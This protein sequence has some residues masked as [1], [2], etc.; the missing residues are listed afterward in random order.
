MSYTTFRSVIIIRKRRQFLRKLPI[1]KLVQS[2]LI[3]LA[4]FCLTSCSRSPEQTNRITDT[5]RKLWNNTMHHYVSNNLWSTTNSYDAGHHVMLP[6]HVAYWS[7]EESWIEDIRH[8]MHDSVVALVE[9]NGEPPLETLDWIHYAYLMSRYITLEPLCEELKETIAFLLAEQISQLWLEKPAWMWDREPFSCMRERIDWKLGTKETEYS[10]YR[11]ILDVDIYVMAI[12]ADL[13]NYE[14]SHK[15]IL[16][17][18]TSTL[19]EILVYANRVLIDR[20]VYVNDEAWLFQPGLWADHR[21]YAYA[22]LS[23]KEGGATQIPVAQI[24]EDSSH[25]H[26]LP[27]W[28]SSLRDAYADYE[29]EYRYYSSLLDGLAHQVLDKVLKAPTK[30]FNGIRMTN[31]MDGSN[32]L[33]RWQY[34]T[35]NGDGYG[36]YELSLTFLLGWW[37]FTNNS[38]IKS[39]YLQ[40]ATCFP[41]TDDVKTTYIGPNTTRVRDAYVTLPDSLDNGLYELICR[42]AAKHY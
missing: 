13:L 1:R 30:E 8:L 28:L 32:G 38:S 5:E 29:D 42:L 20:I 34:A 36:P 39:L 31:Y 26:R 41:L 14:H 23:D 17:E 37:S 6:M 7:N 16:H 18:Y 11:A 10:Y 19:E 15:F 22:G 25:S 35:A 33:Y 21:D 2:L 24:A 27:L 3:C 40:M 4:L 9:Y 12:A